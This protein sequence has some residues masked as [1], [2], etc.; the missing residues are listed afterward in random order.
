MICKTKVKRC[1][2]HCCFLL[3]LQMV[4]SLAAQEMLLPETTAPN[5]V[6]EMIRETYLEVLQREPDAGGLQTYTQQIL[7]EGKG[8]EWLREVLQQSHEGRALRA[9]AKARARFISTAAALALGGLVLGVVFRKRLR[10]MFRSLWGKLS[11]P[12]QRYLH[13][14]A[15]MTPTASVLCLLF[16]YT[17][18]K[19]TPPAGWI[20]CGLVFLV[21]LLAVKTPRW[22]WYSAAVC[23]ILLFL[24]WATFVDANGGHDAASDRDDAVEIAATAVL[25]GT[26]PWSQ[27]SILGLPITTGPTSVL[28]AVPVMAVFGGINVM[29][30]AIWGM[31]ILLLAFADIRHRNNTFFT[32]CLLLFFP[33]FGFRHSLHWSLDELYFAAILSPLLWLALSRKKLVIAG[34]IGGAMALARLSYAPAVIAVGF[35]W[36]LKERPPVKHLLRVAI[37]GSS[38]VLGMLGVFWLI[39]GHEFLEKNFWR[40]SKMGALHNESNPVSS[41]LSSALEALPKGTVGSTALVLGI[42]LLASFAMRRLPHPF[43]HMAVASVLAHTIAFSPG[44]PMDYQ[45]IFLIPALYGLCFSKNV[46]GENL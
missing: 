22:A 33:W 12:H 37:G 38:Y 13:E 44:Y 3:M 45:L 31:F 18:F 19:A 34:G 6:E 35:W 28:M 2:V 9:Q 1:L 36:I 27:R 16:F 5:R 10:H 29:T 23:G 17:Y 26:N 43:Y 30:F 4:S 24:A 46:I 39:G 32:A 41:T 7:D 21:G 8:Q 14:T 25:N 15:F 11:S 40:N 42:T 20:L